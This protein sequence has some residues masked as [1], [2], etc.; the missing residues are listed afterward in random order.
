M[1]LQPLIGFLAY[2]EPKLWPQNPILTETETLH[3]RYDLL[4]QGKF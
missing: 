2:L 4:S 3:E 1:P